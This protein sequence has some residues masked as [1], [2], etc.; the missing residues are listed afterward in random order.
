MEQSRTLEFINVFPVY[1]GRRCGRTF[2]EPPFLLLVVIKT[3][4]EMEEMW[5]RISPASSVVL[6]LAKH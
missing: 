1:G 5:R 4:L 3:E 6:S 2:S